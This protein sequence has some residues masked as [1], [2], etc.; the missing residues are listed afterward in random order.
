[1]TWDKQSSIDLKTLLLATIDKVLLALS[2]LLLFLLIWDSL[3]NQ[4]LRFL[5]DLLYT[6]LWMLFIIEYCL[7]VF[8]AR[9]KMAYV[10]NNLLGILVII[11]PF[12]RPLRLFPVSRF[13]LL[14]ITKQLNDR[15]VWIR[16]SRILEIA[17]LSI[18]LLVLSADLFLF[19]EKGPG[20][21]ITTFSDAIWL[22]VSTMTTTVYGDVYPRTNASRALAT[23]LVVF[24]LSIF[25]V[26][27]AKIASLFVGTQVE[28]ELRVEE[29][30]IG[31][32]SAEEKNIEDL[33]KKVYSKEQ[34]LESEMRAKK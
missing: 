8:F 13:G 18:I 20:A 6:P 33:L 10:R 4:N 22:S 12:L 34:A 19:F 30:E 27:T 23:L 24:G 28:K 3:I 14:I 26:I 32:L 7:Q 1:M 11:F 31:H 2:V 21:T 9:D 17:L 15:L 25:S 16:Q 5:Y 29:K